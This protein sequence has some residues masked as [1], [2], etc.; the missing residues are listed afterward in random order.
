MRNEHN[1]IEQG[2]EGTE[3][4]QKF[5]IN[6]GLIVRRGGTFYIIL[7]QMTGKYRL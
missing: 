4:F 2:I 5:V 7:V 6:S 1:T 3:H